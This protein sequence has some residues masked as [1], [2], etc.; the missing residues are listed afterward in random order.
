MTSRGG[1]AAGVPWWGKVL[2]KLLLARLPLPYGAWRRLGLFLHGSMDNPAYAWRVLS[3]HLDNYKKLNGEALPEVVLELG[4]GDSAF[5]GAF[6]AALGI[7]RTLLV[8]VGPFLHWDSASRERVSAYLAEAQ[9]GLALPEGSGLEGIRTEYHTSGLESLRSLP[10]ASV[11]FIWSQAVLEHLPRRDFQAFLAEMR[12]IIRPEGVLS[13]R[14]DLKDHLGGGLNNLRFRES[15]W[16]STWF[17]KSG[18]YTN[19]LRRS[20]LLAGFIQ[21]GF[22]V[23]V[24]QV[25]SWPQIPTPRE[26]LHDQFRALPE[27]ELLVSGLNIVLRPTGGLK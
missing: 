8:D 24:I 21:A 23:A 14:V 16:E 19:R 3:Q 13:H 17:Q 22:E 15:L 27:E 12:R 18:F 25:E 10:E 9:P 26:M 5:S 11:D 7:R 2:A 4:P 6:G 20:E 1:V